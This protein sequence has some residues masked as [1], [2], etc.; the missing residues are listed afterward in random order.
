GRTIRQ[1][2]DL[3]IQDMDR[4]LSECAR[5]LKPNHFCTIIVGTNDNQLS[6]ALNVPKEEVPGLHQLLIEK[7]SKHGFS[8]MRSLARRISGIAN[9]MRDEYI[10]ILQRN[11]LIMGKMDLPGSNGTKISEQQTPWNTF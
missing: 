6:K 11:N 1:K 8:L 7:A 10:V 9:T 5:V 4:V 3:Y 2:F